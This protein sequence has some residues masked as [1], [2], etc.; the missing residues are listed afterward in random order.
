MNVVVTN[1]NRQILLIVSLTKP[2][3]YDIYIYIYIYILYYYY[4]VYDISLSYHHSI[5]FDVK[6]NCSPLA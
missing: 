4:Y 2:R 5:Y 6:V 1:H 3:M